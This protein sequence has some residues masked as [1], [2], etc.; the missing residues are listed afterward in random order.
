M[1][2]SVLALLV[3]MEPPAIEAVVDIELE[4]VLGGVPTAKELHVMAAVALL[5]IVAV[6]VVVATAA[7]V[8]IGLVLTTRCGWHT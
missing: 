5:P 8:V 1:L 2:D 7:V 4:P 3:V 6:L